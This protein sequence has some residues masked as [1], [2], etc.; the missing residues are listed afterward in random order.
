MSDILLCFLLNLFLN[1]S[2]SILY[3]FILHIVCSITILLLE[4][5]WLYSF[6]SSDNNCRFV[7]FLLGVDDIV[8][9]GNHFLCQGINY[10]DNLD[11]YIPRIC[12]T[13]L[14]SY[15]KRMNLNW[16]VSIILVMTIKVILKNRILFTAR[17]N[18]HTFR[19]F[20]CIIVFFYFIVICFSS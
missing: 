16:S 17:W 1:T 20:M 4:W 12:F 2:A 7:F 8:D 18:T 13:L 19:L 15:I 5:F 10:Q 9:V 3:F 6:W 11:R 14:W